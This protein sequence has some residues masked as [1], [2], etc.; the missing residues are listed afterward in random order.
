MQYLP[1]FILPQRIDF[2][3][4]LTF[5]WMYLPNQIFRML[6]CEHEDRKA[7]QQAANYPHA[8]GVIWHNI[9]AMKGLKIL[10]VKLHVWDSWANLNEEAAKMLL[11]PIKEVTVPKTFILSLPFPAMNRG[12]PHTSHYPWE[13]WRVDEGWAGIDPW[14]NALHCTIHRTSW[15]ELFDFVPHQPPAVPDTTLYEAYCTNVLGQIADP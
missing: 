11:A 8:W 13:S 14:D 10:N 15:S 7:V 5:H 4:N 12:V 6:S 1:L 9:A 3:H 2:I